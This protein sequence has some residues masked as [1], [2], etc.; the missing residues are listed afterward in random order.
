MTITDLGYGPDPEELLDEEEVLDVEDEV[1]PGY[2]EL[3]P[4]MADFL[5]QL[6]ER[7]ILF[8]EELAGFQMFPYQR[9]LSY[10]IIESLILGIAE[11]SHRS[12]GPPEW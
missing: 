11:E 5:Q 7:T 8:C 4:E 2:E 1:D 6:I 3:D 10:R 9:A 12:A